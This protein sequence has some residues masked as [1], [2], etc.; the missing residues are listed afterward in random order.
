MENARGVCSVKSSE[1]SPK[2]I[3]ETQREARLV[4]N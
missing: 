1:E 3:L 2:L 4:D